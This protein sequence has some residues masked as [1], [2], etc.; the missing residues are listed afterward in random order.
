MAKLKVTREDIIKDRLAYIGTLAS[1]LAH[2]INNP[3]N[4]ISLN[5][6]LLEDDVKK[7][8]VS[9]QP[10]MIKKVNRI[11]SETANLQ[12]ILGEF[13]SFARPP[14]LETEVVDI[15]EFLYDI[16]DFLDPEIKKHTINVKFDLDDTLYP[17][18]VDPRQLHQVFINL[19]K[20]AIEAI[21]EKKPEHPQIIVCTKSH[22]TFLE[23]RVSDNGEGIPEHFRDK[24]FE[25]FFTTKENGTGLGLGIVSRI[26]SEHQGTIKLDVED[27][28]KGLT[29]FVITL[30]KSI[31]LGFF[32]ENEGAVK[33]NE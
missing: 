17:I 21:V 29:T 10:R 18:L 1:G 5:I 25:V 30:P 7:L 22:E 19:L 15:N 2:E 9:L 12:K 20:N 11:K 26:L 23:L 24:I 16:I 32:D 14:R 33:N 28:K 27:A 3:L 31:H 6:D 13:L 4:S 8:E